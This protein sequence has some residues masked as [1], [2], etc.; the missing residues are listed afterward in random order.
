MKKKLSVLWKTAGVMAF[1]GVLMLNVTILSKNEGLIGNLDL[2]SLKATA[3]D[4]TEDSS[5]GSSDCPWYVPNS[6]CNKRVESIRVTCTQS[7]GETYTYYNESGSVVGSGTSTNGSI[8]MTWGYQTG[9]YTKSGGSTSSYQATKV[10]CPTD[11][12][13]YSCTP[14]F[15]C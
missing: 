8:T 14:Y 10:N 12:N 3:D 11:G 15:P 1:A 13:K 5:G 9:S 6:Y 7:T 4:G 2:S